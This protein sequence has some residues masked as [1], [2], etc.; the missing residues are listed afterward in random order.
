M[1]LAFIKRAFSFKRNVEEHQIEDFLRCYHSEGPFSTTQLSKYFRKNALRLLVIQKSTG[2]IIFDS[3]LNKDQSRLP[4]FGTGVNKVSLVD[5]AFGACPLSKQRILKSSIKVHDLKLSRQVL[6]TCVY[7]TPAKRVRTTNSV[8]FARS[9]SENINA[10]NTWSNSSLKLPSTDVEVAICILINIDWALPLSKSNSGGFSHTVKQEFSNDLAARFYALLF[11]HFLHVSVLFQTLSDT[12]GRLLSAPEASKASSG[13]TYHTPKGSGGD[14]HEK[15]NRAFMDFQRAFRDLCIPRICR[16][17]WSS[18]SL[19]FASQYDALNG[20]RNLQ[21]RNL[22][23]YENFP[24]SLGPLSV[25]YESLSGS[26]VRGCLCS[27]ISKRMPKDRCHFLAQLVTGIL[28]HHRGWISTVMPKTQNP[29]AIPKWTVCEAPSDDYTHVLTSEGW[30]ENLLMNQH[31]V[32]AGCGLSRHFCEDS[33]LLTNSGTVLSTTII[34]GSGGGGGLQ[35]QQHRDR[36]LALLYLSSYFLRPPHI[37][38]RAHEQLPDLGLADL[39]DLEQRKRKRHR[40]SG[41]YRRKSSSQEDLSATVLQSLQQY[42]ASAGSSPSHPPVGASA[43]CLPG[44]L[45]HEQCR[46]A[47]AAAQALVSRERAAAKQLQQNQLPISQQPPPTTSLYADPPALST[48]REHTWTVGMTGRNRNVVSN[49]LTGVASGGSGEL[50]GAL[51]HSSLAPNM[52]SASASTGAPSVSSS[53]S[54]TST[55]ANNSNELTEIP[56]LIEK[57]YDN[58][59]DSCWCLGEGIGPSVLGRN[60]R[61]GGNAGCRMSPTSL[62]SGDVTVHYGSS[63]EH[64]SLMD[65]DDS[66][67][68]GTVCH[69]DME[70]SDD[71]TQNS[72]GGGGGSGGPELTL[73]TPIGASVLEHYT[74]GLALQAT[75]ESA[76]AFRTRLVA[77]LTAWLHFAPALLQRAVAPPPIFRPSSHTHLPTSSEHQ[78]NAFRCSALLVNVD[79]S[80]V[81]LLTVRSS[82]NTAATNTSSR[83]STSPFDSVASSSRRAT[84][85]NLRSFSPTSTRIKS[86]RTEVNRKSSV[87]SDSDHSVDEESEGTPTSHSRI[88]TPSPLIISLLESVK[89]VYEKSGG[90]SSIAL[91][92]LESGLQSLCTQGCMLADLLV[93]S[94][95]SPDGGVDVPLILKQRPEAVASILGCHRADLPLLLTIASSLSCKAA[96]A[97]E[98]YELDQIW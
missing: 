97:I 14:I 71:T 82:V 60:Y 61:S 98:T 36:L 88:L 40:G 28:M 64:Y 47:E 96:A 67:E 52:T 56:L 27:L 18:L 62:R 81:E 22:D 24:L 39:Y 59:W 9:P 68:V 12:I 84:A 10:F 57:W 73:H 44:R 63:V 30:V 20:S 66:V 16:P 89:F 2:S 70:A 21:D 77:D 6:L 78:Q 38:L 69:A 65:N 32:Q 58:E 42:S 50:S 80:T 29:A 49:L 51:P 35:Q 83:T 48:H 41:N 93:P 19:A 34:F 85:S 13:S 72:T 26:F 79:A 31:L 86:G 5:L 15:I 33:R 7:H 75:T 90:C 4:V 3:L 17:V 92:H 8:S 37:L 54:P 1:S 55:L 95:T 23:L 74:S 45:T 76:V 11:D 53:I 43:I 46:L 25:Q 94:I 87:T 91:R